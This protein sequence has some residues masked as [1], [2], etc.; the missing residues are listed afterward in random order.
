MFI[1][2]VEQGGT[3]Q[4]KAVAALIAGGVLGA[5]GAFL[6]FYI[7][8]IIRLLGNYWLLYLILAGLVALGW[9]VY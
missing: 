3:L 6:G 8:K 9:S 5:F 4:N 7:P 1:G 2:Y